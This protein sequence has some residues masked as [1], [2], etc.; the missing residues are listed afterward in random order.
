M[1]FQYP[2]LTNLDS[3]FHH[4]CVQ[5]INIVICTCIYTMYISS[6]TG[7]VKWFLHLLLQLCPVSVP[8]GG[9]LEV[10]DERHRHLEGLNPP[11]K[12]ATYCPIRLILRERDIRFQAIETLYFNSLRMSMPCKLCTSLSFKNAHS[13]D[14]PS[15]M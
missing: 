8:H 14:W 4:K 1:L 3:S 5:I 6:R 10:L 12:T 7:V 15:C 9:V 11:T 2:H 13:M